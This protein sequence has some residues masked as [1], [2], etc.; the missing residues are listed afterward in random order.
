MG[1]RFGNNLARR[2]ESGTL[3]SNLV[4]QVLLAFKAEPQC[5]VHPEDLIT[6]G[7]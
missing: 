7:R 5:K 6:L 1:S 3:L 2:I 4:P